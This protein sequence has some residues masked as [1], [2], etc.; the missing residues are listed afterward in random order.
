MRNFK[1]KLKRRDPSPVWIILPVH[2]AQDSPVDAGNA[3]ARQSVSGG[4]FDG[5]TYDPTLAAAGG[6]AADAND[7][8]LDDIGCEAVLTL[9]APSHLGGWVISD[10]KLQ[11]HAVAAVLLWLVLCVAL[12]LCAQWGGAGSARR[13]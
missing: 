6:L 12:W 7:L 13:R 2:F 5:F 4:L 1:S 9:S 8:D 3:L 10:S 11:L